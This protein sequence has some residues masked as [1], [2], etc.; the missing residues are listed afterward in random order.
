ME[1]VSS[2]LFG[3]AFFTGAHIP[4][5]FPLVH[6]VIVAVVPEYFDGMIPDLLNILDL[7]M[8]RRLNKKQRPVKGIHVPVSTATHYTGTVFS[9]PKQGVLRVMP[10]GP[11]NFQN[12]IAVGN[13]NSGR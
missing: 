6:A 7:E 10:I 12:L 13:F 8:L 2:L 11:V 1:K 5:G 3:I 4:Q 9:K